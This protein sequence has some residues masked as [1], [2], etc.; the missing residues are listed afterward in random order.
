M[1][2]HA[3]T[4]DLRSLLP[5]ADPS[6]RG[7]AVTTLAAGFAVATLPV[8]AETITTSSEGLSTGE[9]KV[10][11]KDGEVPAYFAHPESGGPFPTILVVQEIFG[12]HEH[13]KDVCRRFAK[14][15]YLAVAPE[16]YARQGD[17]AAISDVQTIIREVVSHVPDAQVMADLDASAAWAKS[18]GKGDTARLGITGFC[19]GGR[20][21]WLYAAHNP[22]LKAGVAWYGRVVGEANELQPRHPIGIAD[23]LKAPVLGLYGGKDQGIPVDTLDRMKAAVAAAGKT[24]EFVIYPEAGHAFNADYRPSYQADAAKDGW[25]RALAWFKEHGVA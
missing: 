25:Q 8:S 7:F 11:V 5:T 2:M 23:E 15:G 9:A 22:D 4:E 18:S 14:Q 21:V 13:I 1:P 19:W 3:F 16:L 6:R 24:A 17:V 10:P 12:V 20:I